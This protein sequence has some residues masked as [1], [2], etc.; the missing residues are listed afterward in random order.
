M[1]F[2]AQRGENKLREEEGGWVTGP[3]GWAVRGWAQ[4]LL[5]LSFF[6]C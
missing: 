3:L 6:L 1:E 4:C 2:C 5:F